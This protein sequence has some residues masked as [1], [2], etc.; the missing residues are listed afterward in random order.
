MPDALL[1][2]PISA[3]PQRVYQAI[4]EQAGLASW[5][6]PDV[7]NAEPRIGSVAEF[8]FGG[9]Y[10]TK[11]EVATLEPDRRVVWNVR[12]GVPEWTNTRVT[13]DLEPTERGTS[14][15]FAHRDYP[16]TDGSFASVTFNWAWYLAS[17][18]TYVEKGQGWPGDPPR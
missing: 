10:V 18:K 7:S 9:G 12:Q 17:L 1:E 15:R 5:W 4:T 11:M 3:P 8:R 6:T 13:W 14:L 2:V 16:S